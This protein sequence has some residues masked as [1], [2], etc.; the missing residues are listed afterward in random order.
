MDSG[1]H[2]RNVQTNAI[3]AFWPETEN[4][5]SIAGSSSVPIPLAR[6]RLFQPTPQNDGQGR[7]ACNFVISWPAL[8]I[9]R[10]LLQENPR[11]ERLG[12]KGLKPTRRF[13][14]QALR[15]DPKTIHIEDFPANRSIGGDAMA[16]FAATV[17]A[18]GKSRVG[19][20]AKRPA[21]CESGA[22][23]RGH[24]NGRGTGAEPDG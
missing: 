12:S 16:K 10:G 5:A 6:L 18:C 15:N 3:F 13:S 17:R 1:N 19:D 23:A 9:D 2:L 22:H 21:A 20:K 11:Y 8:S 24:G 4:D 14:L 7:A